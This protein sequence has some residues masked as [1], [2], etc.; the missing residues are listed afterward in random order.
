MKTLKVT[1]CPQELYFAKQHLS[2]E[3]LTSQLFSQAKPSGTVL[4]P[5]FYLEGV[6]QMVLGHRALFIDTMIDNS[7]NTLRWKQS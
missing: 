4:S 1:E 2:A 6:V 5:P 7:Y 3:R